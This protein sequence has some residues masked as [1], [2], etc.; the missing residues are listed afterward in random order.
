MNREK[1]RYHYLMSIGLTVLAT[2]IVFTAIIFLLFSAGSTIGQEITNPN[3]NPDT[4]IKSMASVIWDILFKSF[5]CLMGF[6]LYI[7]GVIWNIVISY[8]RSATQKN[9]KLTIAVIAG[10]SAF[11]IFPV[12]GFLIS[13]VLQIW[14]WFLGSKEYVND[15]S[16][17]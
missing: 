8:M 15:K 9:H 4:V 1:F 3:S 2:V 7:I 17:Q 13:M 16:I 10:W 14:A 5:F 12:I 6:G 11:F